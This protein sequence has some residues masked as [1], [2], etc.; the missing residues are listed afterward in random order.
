[1]T[2]S[3]AR[4]SFFLKLESSTSDILLFFNCQ[5]HKRA[6]FAVVLGLISLLLYCPP[7]HYIGHL[8]T[9]VVV[10]SSNVPAICVSREREHC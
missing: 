6:M 9:A 1:L 4:S 8:A 2:L 5:I 10:I 7:A 3:N